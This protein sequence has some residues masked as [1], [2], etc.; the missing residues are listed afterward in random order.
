M[1]SCARPVFPTVTDALAAPG[2]WQHLRFTVG[3]DLPSPPP[4]LGRG[5]TPHSSA[6]LYV[7][8]RGGGA[9]LHPRGADGAS[10]PRPVPSPPLPSREL[11]R[12]HPDSVVLCR[13]RQ[14]TNRTENKADLGGSP[15]G[16]R[17]IQT[18]ALGAERAQKRRHLPRRAL[19]IGQTAL[20][21]NRQPIA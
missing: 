7:R 19:G 15:A 13:P 9:P 12:Y 8:G 2:S 1:R 10:P 11:A 14:L 3:V 4:G 21:Q 18:S 20:G 5:Q 16:Q 17:V 6:G